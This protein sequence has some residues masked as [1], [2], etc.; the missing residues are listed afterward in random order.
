MTILINALNAEEILD[1][2]G[3][4]TIEVILNLSNGQQVRASVPSGASTGIHEALELRDKDLKRFQGK[5]VLQAINHIQQII[6]PALINR[7]PNNQ[8]ELD[9]ILLNLDGTPNKSHLGGNT[10]L[11]VSLAIAKAA[12]L[13][14][15]LNLHDYFAKD[16][17]QSLPAP[18]MNLIN[19]GAHSN[20][21]L[22]FQEFMIMPLGFNTLHEAIRCGVEVFHALKDILQKKNLSTNVGDEGG[23]APHLTSHTQ[24]LDLLLMAIE[25]ANY[26][27]GEQVFLALDVASSEFYKD[28]VYHL[29]TENLILN[30]E[31]MVDYLTDLV[32][33]YPIL[34]IEDGMAE[35]DWIGWEFL[36]QKLGSHIQLVGDDLFVTHTDKL[37]KGIEDKVANA[38]LIKPNQVGTLT[39]T[40]D[41]LKYAQEKNYLT[42]ISHRSGET[43][44]TSIADMAVGLNAQQI[45][46]GSLSR[47]DRVAKYNQLLRIETQRPDLIYCGS[48]IRNRIRGYL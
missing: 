15:G 29:T 42:I 34:S 22:N 11:A 30:S 48:E 33:K 32:K 2:R 1:S 20:N 26:K 27:V 45:K 41:A 37:K 39:E 19:G 16:G 43:E 35:E 47:T 25:Q 24:A 3:N 5:G 40:F 38:I 36:T 28:H 14:N 23:F 6:A 44:D 17:L 46:T 10:L 12:A 9:N 18:A 4:P 21:P 31:G 13:I 8:V 7:D